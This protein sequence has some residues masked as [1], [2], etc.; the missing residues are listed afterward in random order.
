[1]GFLNHLI[2]GYRQ[3]RT[4]GPA[5][6]SIAR[7]VLR[8][9]GTGVV[10]VFDIVVQSWHG[11]PLTARIEIFDSSTERV[12]RSVTHT[13]T[14]DFPCWGTT[15]AGVELA[16]DNVIAVRCY[17]RVSLFEGETKLATC[18]S[19][20]FLRASPRPSSPRS[21]AL[22]RRTP[23]PTP[24]EELLGLQPGY[25]VAELKSAL[26]RAIAEWHPDRFGASSRELRDIAAEQ[27]RRLL[28]A[29]ALLKGRVAKRAS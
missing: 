12:F 3:G 5:E 14:P 20:P 17:A 26:R 18:V 6:L 23:L 24:E 29:H 8:E 15:I 11:R 2:D 28:D 19:A 9:H 16:V 22:E 10:A 4:A 1:M 27:T 25:S 13:I 21:N 7:L